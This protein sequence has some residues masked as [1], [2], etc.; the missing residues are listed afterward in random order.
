MLNNKK[1]TRMKLNKMIILVASIGFSYNALATEQTAVIKDPNQQPVYQAFK[2]EV[3]DFGPYK[4]ERSMS[5]VP[6]SIVNPADVVAKKG[7][8]S[9]V[10]GQKLQKIG[11]SAVVRNL[12]TGD[13]STVTGNFILLLENEIANAAGLNLVSVFP[14]T[15]IAVFSIP[16]S[17]DLLT[18]FEQL[19]AIDGVLET[20]IEVAENMFKS[21]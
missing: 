8:L 20:K 16:E 2:N 18:A 19:K 17:G 13:L 3:P 1:E 9:F 15:P 10:S 21:N 4:V 5:S 14:G 11:K 6:T 7:A 12:L